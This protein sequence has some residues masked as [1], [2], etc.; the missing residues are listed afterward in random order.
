MALRDGR[1]GGDD[2]L[3]VCRCGPKLAP[4]RAPC[5]LLSSSDGVS[6]G[7]DTYGNGDYFNGAI[8]NVQIYAAAISADGIASLAAAAPTI[9]NPAAASPSPVTGTTAALSVAIDDDGESKRPTP[10]PLRE[11]RRPPSPSRPT[12]RTPP[13]TTTSTFAAPGVYS[14]L[15]T[16]VDAFGLEVTSAVNVQVISTLTT[17]DVMPA[18]VNLDAGQGQQF[19]ALG[20]DQFGTPLATQPAF[21]WSSTVGAIST[22]GLLTAQDTSASG[23][24]TAGL[25]GGGTIVGSS[26]VT[27]AEHAPTTATAASA[28][29]GTVTGTTTA[30]SVQGT[31]V[32][33]DVGSLTYTWTTTQQPDGVA[34]PAFS[35]NNGTNAGNNTTVAFSAAGSYE[36]A[37]TIADPVD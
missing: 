4:D 20:L 25:A 9:T 14:F 35:A 26:A 28:T 27:V 36:F 13:S 12:A 1:A 33:P 19:A 23:T 16:A 24:V 21:T 31:D 7:A 6:V 30:L 32:D 34:A 8:D 29:P 18:S 5:A 37:V 10:G 11:R 3:P 17:I 15:V 22:A 2:R